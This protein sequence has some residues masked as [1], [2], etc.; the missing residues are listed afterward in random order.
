MPYEDF[1]LAWEFWTTIDEDSYNPNPPDPTPD[2]K[3]WM[4]K[5]WFIILVA[6]LVA[7]IVLVAV[8]T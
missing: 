5:Y 6:A 1:N 3:T 7:G 4:E 8:L 2:E